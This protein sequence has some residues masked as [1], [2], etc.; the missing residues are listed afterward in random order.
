MIRRNQHILTQIYA[1]CDFMVI[2]MSFL[3]SYWIKFQSGWLNFESPLPVKTYFLWSCVYAGITIAIGFFTN[4]YIPKRKKSFSYDAFKIIQIHI[5]GL[6]VLLSFMY[7]Y[8]EAHIS[9]EF[10][11]IFLVMNIGLL[12]T[13]RFIV[14]QAL[15]NLREKGYN[16]QFV[17]ILG[18]GTLGKRFYRK[19]NNRPEFGFQVMGFLDD[20]QTE[21]AEEEGGLS[22]ILGKVND[23]EQILQDYTVD[24]V[25]MALPLTAHE[26][27]GQ[28]I[29]TCEK[30]GVRMMIIPDFYDFLPAKPNFDNFA[31]MP[32][33]NI[34]DIPL[35]DLGNRILKR[36][37][38]IVFSLAAIIVTLPLLIIIAALIKLSSP[39]P[40]IFKQERVGLNRKKF[41][42][43][44]FRSMKVM[45]EGASDTQWTVEN[46]PRRTKLG[47][48]L[49]KTSID[50]LPQFFNVLL[51]HMSV[52][53][54]RPERPFFVEQFKE[55]IPKYMVKH[56]IRPGITG[57]AQ[58][59]GL[60]GDTSI[61]DRIQY[62]IFYIE[63]WTLLFDIK[64]IW[65]TVINGFINKNA[66]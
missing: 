25:V 51:G 49:R 55:E 59:N 16:K 47:A 30:A 1:L 3:L 53:G 6:L 4:F 22:P 34:R 45:P 19:L 20:Y 57:W 56:H 44:K 8:K 28:I 40:I 48:F 23:L 43:Y 36:G 66:Y 42:M 26:K 17:L 50:E 11:A 33:I 12:G 2:L 9:R 24:E 52:V 60:R 10:L 39:G 61:K 31:G 46:D 64:I 27:Y 29:S 18:A 62:D 15:R 41:Y 54:P 35:D 58:S 21:H 5:I 63:N 13:Y 14:K 37:F 38:D 7:V 32:L 65:R